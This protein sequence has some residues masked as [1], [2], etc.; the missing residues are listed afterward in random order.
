[1]MWKEICKTFLPC[2][3]SP[4]LKVDPRWQVFIRDIW[5]TPAKGTMNQIST[6][7]ASFIFVARCTYWCPK[8][9]FSSVPSESIMSFHY[10]CHTLQGS[11]SEA[12]VSSS[13]KDWFHQCGIRNCRPGESPSASFTVDC[14]HSEFVLLYIMCGSMGTSSTA[15]PQQKITLHGLSNHI[16]LIAWGWVCGAVR[17]GCFHSSFFACSM[18]HVVPNILVSES[19]SR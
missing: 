5:A 15:L 6:S 7:M 13:S 2:Y 9:F 16:F 12:P 1:M 18:S 10:H 8:C 11:A 4:L 17:S 19:R 14:S 3:L